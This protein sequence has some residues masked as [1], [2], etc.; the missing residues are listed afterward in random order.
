[1]WCF[2]NVVTVIQLI[3]TTKFNGFVWVGMNGEAGQNGILKI[4]C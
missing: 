4:S 3:G 2:F 1:M